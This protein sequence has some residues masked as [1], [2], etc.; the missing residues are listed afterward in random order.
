MGVRQKPHRLPK[1]SYQGTAIVALTL[2]VQD[3]N[4][5]FNNQ[6]IVNDVVTI[7]SE[8]AQKH[9]VVI[10]VYCFMPD[11]LHLVIRGVKDNTNLL[12]FI[13]AFKQKTGFWMATNKVGGRWQKNYYD[14]VL[15]REESL[16]AYISYILN[17]LVRKGLAAFWQEYSF[18][19]SIGGNLEDVLHSLM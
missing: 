16:T 8:M 14:H 5:V 2:C 19:G 17:N 12:A 15:R 1:D 4:Q 6:N 7:L 13:A 9:D 10:L 11:H 3:R 18:I